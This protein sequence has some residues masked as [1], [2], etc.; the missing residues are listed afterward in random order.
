MKR[1]EFDPDKKTLTIDIAKSDKEISLYAYYDQDLYDVTIKYNDEFADV[2]EGNY[3]EGYGYAI[4]TID[5]D[6]N[7]LHNITVTFKN[8]V[9]EK[10]TYTLKLRAE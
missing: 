4:Y 8:D 10:A 5:V 3:R 1:S 6:T 7:D 9:G 2:S